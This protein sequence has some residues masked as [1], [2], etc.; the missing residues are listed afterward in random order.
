VPDARGPARSRDFEDV[1][2][3]ASRLADNGYR[4]AVLTGVHIGAYESPDGRRLPELL[5]S[6]TEIEGLVR[7]RL[8]SVEPREVTPELA[9]LI[10]ENTAICSHLHVPMES[11]SDRVLAR[12]RRG[13]TRA[14]YSEAVRRVT[15]RDPYCGLGTDVMV[16][17]PGETDEDFADTV[18]LIESLPFTYLHVFSYSPRSGTPAATM[19]GQ[20]PPK[21]AKRRSRFLRELGDRLSLEFRAGLTGRTLEVLAEEREGTG[22]LIG[23]ADNYVRVE[24]EGGEELRGKFVDVEIR[25]VEAERTRGRAV[26][27]TAR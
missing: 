23:L 14:M 3:Q 8:G 10:V 15:D 22:P 25:T 19:D 16:A 24:I 4:E 2:R 9:E 18:E 1:L 12:M 27:G 5:E 17:F 7:L 11:G 26:P 6:L 21:E 20:I 13:Y